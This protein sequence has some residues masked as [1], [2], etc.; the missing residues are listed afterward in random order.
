MWRTALF[1]IHPL[2]VLNA[3]A[4]GRFQRRFQRRGSILCTPTELLSDVRLVFSKAALRLIPIPRRL[5][6]GKSESGVGCA[7]Q[8]MPGPVRRGGKMAPTIVT[9]SMRRLGDFGAE[10]LRRTTPS[11]H[12]NALY[13]LHYRSDRLLSTSETKL[14]LTPPFLQRCLSDFY[15]DRCPSGASSRPRLRKDMDTRSRVCTPAA[16]INDI[17]Q[18]YFSWPASTMLQP[19]LCSTVRIAGTA[20]YIKMAVPG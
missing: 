8:M 13:A 17:A 5:G 2:L 6:A 19:R 12:V 7:A 20:E 4:I 16:R 9:T 14:R 11:M 18:D 3:K 15:D 10:I 1:S